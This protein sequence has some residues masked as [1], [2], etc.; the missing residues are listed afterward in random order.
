MLQRKMKNEKR[1]ELTTA[2]NKNSPRGSFAKKSGRK[3]SNGLIIGIN[4][5]GSSKGP[6]YTG[7]C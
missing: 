4:A 1:I 3:A 6:H 5:E 7:R 2:T